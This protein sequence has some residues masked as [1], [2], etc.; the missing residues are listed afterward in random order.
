[1]MNIKNDNFNRNVIL[2]YIAFQLLSR[3]GIIAIILTKPSHHQLYVRYTAVTIIELLVLDCILIKQLLI[4][5]TTPIKWIGWR[6]FSLNVSKGIG[7]AAI[8]LAFE[9]GA[10][11]LCGKSSSNIV[12]NVDQATRQALLYLAVPLFLSPIAEEIVFRKAITDCITNFINIKWAT[13]IGTLVFGLAHFIIDGQIFIYLLM[14]LFMQ[15]IY[16]K[17]KNISLNI[18]IHI[19][20]NAYPIAIML[21]TR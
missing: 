5:H 8:F 19:L 3:I 2:E 4:H 13:I 7:L 10:S 14:G 16:N 9:V 12:N 17:W 20:I 18:W 6:K 15:L 21:L 1:M 11:M